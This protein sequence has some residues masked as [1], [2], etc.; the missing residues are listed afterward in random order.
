MKKY[1]NSLSIQKRI[2]LLILIVL[3]LFFAI[4]TPVIM[5]F[6]VKKEIL[7]DNTMISN[8][9][10]SDLEYQ[11][12]N[13]INTI[14]ERTTQIE[15]IIVGLSKISLENPEYSK[16][17]ITKIV[18]SEKK[19]TTSSFS[20]YPLQNNIDLLINE[21]SKITNSNVEF[22]QLIPQGFI[23]TNQYYQE[24]QSRSDV[25]L[26]ITDS[27]FI[28]S[29][30]SKVRKELKKDGWT[31]SIILPVTIKGEIIAC[32]KVS[33]INF[34]NKELTNYFKLKNFEEK[35]IAF[36]LKTDGS[37][38][39][40]PNSKI[41]K[42][43]ASDFIHHLEKNS[44]TDYNLIFYKDED[45]LGHY[46]HYYY[47]KNLEAFICFS[48]P[49]SIYM[50]DI[51]FYRLGAF[52]FVIF[53]VGLMLIGA[54]VTLRSITKPISAATKILQ[55]MS[56]GRFSGVISYSRDD[57]IG[58]I[59]ASVNKLQDSL[60]N[61]VEFA[62]EIGKGNLEIDYQ[63]INDEDELGIALLDMQKSL[64]NAKKE[65][66]SRK[67]DEVKQRW[68]SEGLAKFGEI[69]RQNND[70]IKV[71]SDEFTNNLINYLEINQGGMFI[72]NDEN[73]DDLKLDLVSAFAYNRKKFMQ[74]TVQIGEGIIGA[75]AFE[76][77]TVYMTRIP[78]DYIHITSGLGGA[79]P[80]S[81]LLVPLK[82]EDKVFGVLELASFNEFEPHQI[83]F[84]EKLSDSLASTIST[85]KINAKTKELLEA[86]RIQAEE[87]ASQ[88]EE[89]RQ[90]MEELQTTQEESARRESELTG[91]INAIN[92]STL[93]IEL[94]MHGKVISANDEFLKIFKTSENQIIDTRLSSYSIKQEV[95]EIK[96]ISAL[97]SGE[98]I[99]QIS[100]YSIGNEDVWLSETYTTVNDLEGVPYK[101][102]LM[103]TD[104]SD[105]KKQESI[106]NKNYEE[107]KTA[108]EESLKKE[109]ELQ[110]INDAV[111][112]SSLVFEMDINEIIVKANQN[113]LDFLS[114]RE[115]DIVGK[116][117]K[118]IT[119]RNKK[120]YEQLWDKLRSGEFHREVTMMKMNEKKTWLDETYAPILDKDGN[121]KK[122]L[123]ICVDVTNAVK[124]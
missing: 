33:A 44:A 37:F 70:N 1:L 28:Q 24:N 53:C 20:Y 18:Y 31:V 119:S 43:K 74:K 97:K 17:Q 85:T 98:T 73:Q 108:R 115:E 49:E 95:D 27:E 46:L 94:N 56:N 124:K 57:E 16:N 86:T 101:I 60:K 41:E 116:S 6:I 110:N 3:V 38:I 120:D 100:Q 71:L 78:D 62:T 118:E 66:E 22:Y 112:T 65:E 87:L 40:K 9:Q 117:M 42:I 45:N 19:K 12:N 54:W 89:M 32:I 25:L 83:D 7:S 99:K 102:L 35:G 48:V 80:R 90:N 103:A 79:N 76:K 51:R 75:C 123:V 64:K 59:V 26:P 113:L 5:E 84:V 34:S 92:A 21:I 96:L 63:A 29:G 105:L 58:Q 2:A 107:L 68:I 39:I 111:N 91:V 82:L 13:T 61:T 77:E 106:M 81:L 8:S 11:I 93:F 14:D 52:L 10:I 30:K 109:I 104:I 36:L 55:D 4:I 67:E 121:T 23:R 69:L 122:V 88:E 50:Q 114:I 15:E 72:L 47:M